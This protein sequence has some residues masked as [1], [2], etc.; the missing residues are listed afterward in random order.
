MNE[1]D[2]VI[3][4]SGGAD[5]V[6]LLDFAK[7]LGKTPFC[8][9][10]DYEQLHKEELNVASNICEKRNLSYQKVYLKD[11]NVK[12][13]LT[14]G[15]K[16]IYNGVSIY[17]VPARNTIFLSIAYGI[18]ESNNI[19]EIWIGCDYSDFEGLFPDCTQTYI[20]SYNKML[21]KAA[22]NPIKVYAPLLGLTKQMVL[23]MLEKFGTKQEDIYSGYGEHA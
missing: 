16:G 15:E 4:F 12:S 17:N 6:L 2:L 21:E 14:T 23:T 19:Q 18:A 8:L 11:Y 10:I 3:L 7:M 13:G 22:V 20:G 5:S 1:Y 9:L